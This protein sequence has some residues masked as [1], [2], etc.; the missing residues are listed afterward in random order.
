VRRTVIDA[1][2]LLDLGDQAHA[3]GYGPGAVVDVVRLSTGS[4]LVTLSDE[5]V[6]DLPPV[7]PV[8][9]GRRHRA[10]AAGRRG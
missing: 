1:S 3:A 6:I 4:L 10:L 9:A 5:P 8:T 7:K 2:G